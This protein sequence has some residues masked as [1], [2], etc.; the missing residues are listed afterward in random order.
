MKTVSVLDVF[1]AVIV[2]N[3]LFVVC[4]FLFL[5]SSQSK[6]PYWLRTRAARFVRMQRYRLGE[7][8]R[9]QRRMQRQLGIEPHMSHVR[10]GTT[11]TWGGERM[12]AGGPRFFFV[13]FSG[14]RQDDVRMTSVS[15]R[16]VVA[17]YSV[18]Y[19]RVMVCFYI[20]SHDEIYLAWVEMN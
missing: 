18:R 10:M 9:E 2:A 20:V 19:S 15:Y 3:F 17:M 7:R 14:W 13:L 12:D 5:L 11:F 16:H 4:C 1:L 6:V 8:L